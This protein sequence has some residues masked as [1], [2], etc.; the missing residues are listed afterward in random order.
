MV[1]LE[2]EQA[3]RKSLRKPRSQSQNLSFSDGSLQLNT[4][5]P[6]LYG[7]MPQ[8]FP[9]YSRRKWSSIAVHA[10]SATA[11]RSVSLVHFSQVQKF[12]MMSVHG[13][14]AKPSAV[15]LDS[16]TVICIWNIWEPSRP[17]KVLV[18]ES[19]VRHIFWHQRDCLN[20]LHSSSQQS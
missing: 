3:E 15:R 7:T 13:P 11:G 10:S 6:F 18:Y 20:L 14:T 5:L 17:Q 12:T 2:E 16:C 19:D 9:R 8:P 4:R 1:L